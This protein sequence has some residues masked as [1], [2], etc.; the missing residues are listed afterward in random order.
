MDRPA[1]SQNN[2]YISMITSPAS[3]DFPP[4]YSNW[5]PMHE[6]DQDTTRL[7]DNTPKEDED[8]EPS[9]LQ[10]GVVDTEP[11]DTMAWDSTYCHE[12]QCDRESARPQRLRRGRRIQRQR[13]SG[14]QTTTTRGV[15]S[16][17]NTGSS[18]RGD[19]H[20]TVGVASFLD[21]GQRTDKARGSAATTRPAARNLTTVAV[22]RAARNPALQAR[23]RHLSIVLCP[24][25]Q[26]STG[27]RHPAFPKTILEYHL[28][29]D[30]QLD[31]LAGFYHQRSPSEWSGQYPCP[32]KWT[33]TLT[34]ADKRRKFGRFIGL[35]GC[36]SPIAPPYV[37]ST[38]EI[39]E[40]ARQAA[41]VAQEDAFRQL[42]K[43][44]E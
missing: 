36:E 32:V 35:R 16:V 29:S 42:Y 11:I 22:R 17:Q 27:H 20:T 30:A 5:T 7:G 38:E 6:E 12:M 25:V 40:A 1:G 33:G 14:R 24:L 15:A 21:I 19:T 34:T 18:E 9:E 44:R 31:D 13:L 4:I 10:I 37:P 2:G 39:A 41:M 26:M 28:L 8:K 43:G 3:P 23:L